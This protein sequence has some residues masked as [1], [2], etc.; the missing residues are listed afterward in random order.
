MERDPHDDYYHDDPD[1]AERERR[2]DDNRGDHTERIVTTARG[3]VAFPAL[4]LVLNGFLGLAFV[5]IL[6]VPLL[7][8]PEMMVKA[9]RDMAAQRPPGPDRQEAEQEAD[10]LEQQIQQNPV[11]LRTEA[12]IY[13]G[14]L[15]FANLLAIVGGLSMRALGSYQLSLAGAIVSLVPMLTGFSCCCTGVPLG[16]WALIVLL[17]PAVKAGFTTSRG[18]AYPSDR[19]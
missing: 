12:A 2:P 4:L 8:Q 17:N 7:F 13:V 19:Y 3:A 16:L 9:M 14:I 6:S 18:F 5:A 15:A 10:Q 1:R 11:A